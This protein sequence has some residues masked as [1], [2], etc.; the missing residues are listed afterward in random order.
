MAALLDKALDFALAK[1]GKPSEFKLKVKQKSVIK[2]VVC[3]KRDMLGVLPRG[4]GKSLIFHVLNDVFD[5]VDYLRV[6]L[7]NSIPKLS[8]FRVKFSL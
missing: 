2:A 7:D 1:A 6:S 8:P 3:S 5:F 4:F